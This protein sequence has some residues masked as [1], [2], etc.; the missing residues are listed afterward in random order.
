MRNCQNSDW[1]Q[2]ISGI[3]WLSS[4]HKASHSIIRRSE[5]SL[6]RFILNKSILAL[7]WLPVIFQV[8]TNSLADYCSSTF[9]GTEVKMIP[10][11]VPDSFFFPFLKIGSVFAIFQALRTSPFPC[12]FS[13]TIA[14]SLE[15][16]SVDFVCILRWITA[17]PAD[18]TTS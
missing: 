4:V 1:S 17:G 7:T 14:S 11:Q 10:L 2:E 6:E 8:L 18:L 12:M 15:I 16:S 5:A 13:K 3:Y 9:P